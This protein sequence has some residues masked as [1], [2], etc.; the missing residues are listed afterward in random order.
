ML[1][2]GVINMMMSIYHYFLVFIIYSF[3]G[4]AME[5]ILTLVK[6]G[7]F[8]NRGFLIGPCCPIYGFGSLL[9]TCL[10]RTYTHDYIVLFVLAMAICMILEYITSYIMEKLFKARWWDYSDQK[11]NINGRICLE[12]AV[13]FGLGALVVVYVIHPVV[14]NLLGV[15]NNTTTLILSVFIFVLFLVDIIISFKIISK[16]KNTGLKIRKDS[17]EEIT[18]KIKEYLITQSRLTKRLISAFPNVQASI[19]NIKLR[20][21]ELKRELAKKEAI[22]KLEIEEKEFNLKKEFQEKEMKL[23]KNLETKQNKLKK[24]SNKKKKK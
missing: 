19:N 9:I 7:R 16:F 15:M 22:L 24:M 3:I 10:L 8:V 12:T 17:T 13:P 23:K 20:Q 2:I 11:Y 4:W 5:V 18:K 1:T 21:Q 14:L 6:T